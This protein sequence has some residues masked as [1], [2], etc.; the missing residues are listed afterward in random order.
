[1]KHFKNNVKP[2]CDSYS[3]NGSEAWTTTTEEANALR[4]YRNARVRKMYG[5]AKEGERWIVRRKEEMNIFQ[6][7]N[8]GKLMKS[9]TTVMVLSR[10]TAGPTRKTN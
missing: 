2:H 10:K 5:P 9:Q 3:L 8:A 4:I 6:E 7:A 1:L